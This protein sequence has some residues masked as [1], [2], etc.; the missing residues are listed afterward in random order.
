MPAVAAVFDEPL[1]ARA[2][3]RGRHAVQIAPVSDGILSSLQFP[4]RSPVN[5]GRGEGFVSAI[6]VVVE[7]DR[8]SRYAELWSVADA[9]AGIRPKTDDVRHFDLECLDVRRVIPVRRV[10]RGIP[11][12]GFLHR[13][14]VLSDA[15]RLVASVRF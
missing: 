7:R 14:I 6:N 3:V 8:R 11:L 2:R 12:L 4:D 5:A 10:G 15:A 1:D 9:P 13:T